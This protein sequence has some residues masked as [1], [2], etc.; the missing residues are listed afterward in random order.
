MARIYQWDAPPWEAR[1]YPGRELCF[2][3]EDGQGTYC[4]CGFCGDLINIDDVNECPKCHGHLVFPRAD[5]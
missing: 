3:S 4:Y 2:D 5:W 1:Q